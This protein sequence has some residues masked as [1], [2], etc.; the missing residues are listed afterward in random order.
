MMKALIDFVHRHHMLEQGDNILCAVSGGADSVAMLYMLGELAPE[1]G[2]SLACA[3]Y[4]HGIRGAEA[5]RD[6]DF[7]RKLCQKLD[8]PFRAGRG[9]VP[10]IA[11]ER[12]LGLEEA[13]RMARYEFLRRCAE[14]LGCNKIATAH[15]AADNA[16]TLLMN[17]LRGSGLRGACGIA[18]VRGNIIRPILCLDRPEIEA[19]LNEKNIP[20]VTDSTNLTEDYARNRMRARVIAPLR[21]LNPDFGVKILSA[22]ENMRADEDCLQAMAD[23]FIAAQ[24]ET[25]SAADLCALPEP[26]SAR[27]ILTL[28]PGAYRSHV[29]AVLALA[30]QRS[31]HGELD[32]PGTRVRRQYDRMSFGI[33]MPESPQER[34][35]EPGQNFV[36]GEFSVSCGFASAGANSAHFFSFKTDGICGKISISPRREGDRLRLPG[37]GV[38]KTL[39]KLFS[40]ARIPPDERGLVPV[41]RDEKGVLA[42]Y[43]FGQDERAAASAGES[44]LTIEINKNPEG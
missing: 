24:G 11:R 26:V 20:F 34:T 42:V 21:E 19:Y 14:K 7:V 2:F 32:L 40:E 17:L 35:V 38:T 1:M 9:D 15:N 31:A 44:S 37:R 39:K 23:D 5:D 43:G 25:I 33:C 22:C 41:L 27:V 3:H 28:A 12:G 36:W 18:P 8:I 10:A 4:N 6:E 29:R 30:M 16:E 13:G